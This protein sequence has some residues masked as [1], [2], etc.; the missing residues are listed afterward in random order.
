[1]NRTILIAAVCVAALGLL[2][3]VAVVACLAATAEE[4][5]AADA[6]VKEFSESLRFRKVEA[7]DAENTE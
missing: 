6:F 1:M 3:C 5:A 7:T 2:L 4:T